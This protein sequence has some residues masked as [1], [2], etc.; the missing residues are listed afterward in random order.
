MGKYCS[1]CKATK[2]V[3]SSASYCPTCGNSFGEI[4][5]KQDDNMNLDM[6]KKKCKADEAFEEYEYVYGI[7]TIGEN[8]EAIYCSSKTEYRISLTEDALDDDTELRLL[9][10]TAMNHHLR[11]V[12]CKKK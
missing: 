4:V 8:T 2:E 12:M 6:L 5:K 1:N 11:G 9:K 10:D 7:V 3:N